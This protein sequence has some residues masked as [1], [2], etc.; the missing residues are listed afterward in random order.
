MKHNWNIHSAFSFSFCFYFHCFAIYFLDFDGRSMRACFKCLWCKR[1]GFFFWHIKS[2]DIIAAIVTVF[3]S[4]VFKVMFDENEHRKNGM[5]E[6]SPNLYFLHSGWNIY[7]TYTYNYC[8]HWFF[9]IIVTIWELLWTKIITHR[10]FLP[11]LSRLQCFWAKS[12]V[13]HYLFRSHFL[14]FLLYNIFLYHLFD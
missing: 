10:L 12:L 2:T 13:C 1:I 6:L 9:H 8:S 11:L 4:S 5:L 14:F 7:R 3:G